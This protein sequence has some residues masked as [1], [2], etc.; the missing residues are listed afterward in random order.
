MDKKPV[1]FK[2]GNVTS[3]FPE[4][5]EGSLLINPKKKTLFYDSDTERISLQDPQT[6]KDVQTLKG[7]V[8]SVKKSVQS[9]TDE[10]VINEE[11]NSVNIHNILSVGGDDSSVYVNDRK[12][13][14]FSSGEEAP[15]ESTEG[16]FYFQYGF[17]MEDFL[18]FLYPVNTVYNSVVNINPNA[19]FGGT[20]ESLGAPTSGVY[21]WKRTQ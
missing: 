7:E 15:G 18:D 21:S 14:E 3:S 1:K 17:S 8:S 10:I 6:Q 11:E 2:V 12:L 20:W 13:P 9:L 4:R 19:L 5:E 16:D